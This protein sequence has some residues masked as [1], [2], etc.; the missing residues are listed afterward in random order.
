VVKVVYICEQ[1][2]GATIWVS[3]QRERRRERRVVEV[4]RRRGRRIKGR[5]EGEEEEKE[6]E[7][8]GLSKDKRVLREGVKVV[9]VGGVE[10][11]KR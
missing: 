3:K 9:R 7:D 1:G 2:Y 11:R 6:G 4:M 5:R 8:E 10:W